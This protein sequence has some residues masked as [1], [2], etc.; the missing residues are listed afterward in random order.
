M[1]TI[2]L[3]HE[4]VIK[5]LEAVREALD[6]LGLPNPP[7]AAGK[8]KLTYVTKCNEREQNI[9]QMVVDYKK[10]VHKNIRDTKE[11]VDLLKEQDKAIA[12]K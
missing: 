7:K 5:K 4:A 1:T 9:H 6:A 11:N 3:K 12:R 2:K 10:A 8:N